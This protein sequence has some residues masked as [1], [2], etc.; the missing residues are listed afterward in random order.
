MVKLGSQV[1][2]DYRDAGYE[3]ISLSGD[4]LILEDSGGKQE[5]WVKNNWFPGYVI[6]FQGVGYEF[7]T[8]I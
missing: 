1:R 4:E 6:E 5:L 7:V 8:S 3:F 2:E